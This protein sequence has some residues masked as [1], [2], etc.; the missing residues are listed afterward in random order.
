MKEDFMFSD[1]EL[2]AYLDGESDYA[3]IDM[4]NK[5]L[6]QDGQLR[7]RIE[8]L[9]MSRQSVQSAFDS[10]LA[11]APEMN[12]QEPRQ[13]NY[14][15]AS[16]AAVAC[17]VVVSFFVGWG[18]SYYTSPQ[19]LQGWHGY[20]AAY[21]AL[22]SPSTLAHLDREQSTLEAELKRV[23][24]ALGKDIPFEGLQVS[25]PLEY[26]RAQILGFQGQPLIQLAFLSPMNTPVALCIIRLESAENSDLQM[27]TMEGMS[28]VAWKKDGYGYLLIGGKDQL[29]LQDVAQK[30]VQYL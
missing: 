3:R 4:I 22:Y 17:L 6:A 24:L 9:S 29:M 1:E 11:Q 8:Q 30:F 26:K 12:L 7:A 16:I 19:P 13:T 20:V 5:A 15:I 18:G 28:S 21:Q 25:S 14:S 27:A 2:T 10:L 23:S